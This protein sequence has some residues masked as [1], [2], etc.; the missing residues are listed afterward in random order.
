MF[1]QPVPSQILLQDLAENTF[2]VAAK[3]VDDVVYLCQGWTTLGLF[4][5]L[6]YGGY[7]HIAHKEHHKYCI[8]VYDR[9][10]GEVSY[11]K[12]AAHFTIGSLATPIIVSEDRVP[13][14]QCSPHPMSCFSHGYT[15]KLDP[16]DM[17][18]LVILTYYFF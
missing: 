2:E 9:L 4:Y 3:H 12:P 7:I 6:K 13:I 1:D 17:F 5:N 18:E 15:K 14:E 16:S 8:R 10:D 11:P